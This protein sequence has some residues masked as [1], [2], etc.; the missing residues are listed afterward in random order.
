[1][2]MAWLV[3]WLRWLEAGVESSKASAFT[4]F[5]CAAGFGSGT[6]VAQSIE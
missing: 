5:T 3:G 4:L 2:G 6:S 1:M